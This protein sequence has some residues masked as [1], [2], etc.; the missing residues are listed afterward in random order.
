[1]EA[2]VGSDGK[3]GDGGEIWS[4]RDRKNVG[5][6]GKTTGT[7][8]EAGMCCAWVLAVTAAEALINM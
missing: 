6:D 3:G 8:C 2:F 7:D 1:M 4:G 5:K